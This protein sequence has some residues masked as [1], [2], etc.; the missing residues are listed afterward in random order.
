MPW[1]I[2]LTYLNK[3]KSRMFEWKG[4]EV[5]LC[6]DRRF[7]KPKEFNGID[8]P[9]DAKDELWT[10][11]LEEIACNWYCFIWKFKKQLW[12]HFSIFDIDI[13]LMFYLNKCFTYKYSKDEEPD[14]QGRRCW[15]KPKCSLASSWGWLIAACTFNLFGN[16]RD[17][18]GRGFYPHIS[19]IYEKEKKKLSTS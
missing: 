5:V 18:K 6:Q 8:S 16:A 4:G 2:S 9:S 19:K 7:A 10:R 12:W 3:A 14:V 13:W 15:E 17:F 1:G 11:Y